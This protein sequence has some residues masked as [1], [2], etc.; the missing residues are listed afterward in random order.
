MAI[1]ENSFN[2]LLEVALRIRNKKSNIPFI[3]KLQAVSSICCQTSSAQFLHV[4]GIARMRML[5]YLLVQPSM[6]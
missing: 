4:S 3:E 6:F 5:R 1:V 2:S